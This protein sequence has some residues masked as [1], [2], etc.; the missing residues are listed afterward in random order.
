MPNT[1]E[2]TDIRSD[3]LV[4]SYKYAA[5][6]EGKKDASA[7]KNDFTD[8]KIS[9]GMQTAVGLA[10]EVSPSIGLCSC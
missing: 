1:K 9:E 5:A 7:N 10:L 8:D 3:K 6:T 2:T 4:N